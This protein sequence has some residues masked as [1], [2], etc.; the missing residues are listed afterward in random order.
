VVIKGVLEPVGLPSRLKVDAP[1]VAFAAKTTCMSSLSSVLI[2]EG[3]SVEVTMVVIFLRKTSFKFS[4][5]KQD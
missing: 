2:L 4:P 3:I 5:I 1:I